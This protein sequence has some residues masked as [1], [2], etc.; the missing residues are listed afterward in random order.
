MRL[1]SV[2]PSRQNLR[3]HLGEAAEDDEDQAQQI[4]NQH[5]SGLLIE[6]RE[7][8]QVAAGAPS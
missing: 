3:D 6:D 2:F 8:R 7:D 1:F 5:H 4:L